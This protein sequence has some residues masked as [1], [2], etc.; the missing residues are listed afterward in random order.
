MLPIAR[1]FILDAHCISPYSLFM[2]KLFLRKASLYKPP[3]GFPI[4]LISLHVQIIN[5]P[6]ADRH[7]ICSMIASINVREIYVTS[8]SQLT[9]IACKFGLPCSVFTAPCV[10]WIIDNLHNAVIIIHSFGMVKSRM[11]FFYIYH[12]FHYNFKQHRADD[13]QANLYYGTIIRIKEK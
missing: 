11:I 3:V 2:P 5:S 8:L 4:V 6:R 1:M 7:F 13:N 9:L 12:N 10:A